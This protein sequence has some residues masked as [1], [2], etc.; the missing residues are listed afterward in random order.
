MDFFAE[1]DRARRNLRRLIVLF[2]AA[3]LMLVVL[4]NSLV[5]AFL[6]LGNDYSVYAGG[7]GWRGFFAY[8]SLDRFLSVGVTVGATVGLVSLVRWIQLSSGGRHVAESMGGRQVLPQTRDPYE[9]RCLNIVEELSLAANMP[10]PSLYVLPDERGINA[11]AAGTTTADAVV[12]VTRGCILQLRRDELQG[13]I[14]H[15]FSHILNGDMRLGIRLAALLKGIT[16][17]GDVGHFLLRA[18]VH[19]IGPGSRRRGDRS[20]ALPLLG[21]GL[22]I[23][24]WLGALAA[25]L[26]KAAISRQK[27][28]LADAS[29]VQ[30]SRDNRGIADALKVIGGFRPGSFIHSARAAELGHIF[31]GEVRHSLWD[32][33][34]THPPLELRIRRLEPAWDGEFIRRPE[35]RQAPMTPGN[36]EAGV[37]R[38]A[39][40]TAAMASAVAADALPAAALTEGPDTGIGVP[41]AD[42]PSVDSEGLAGAIPAELHAVVEEPLGAMAAAL[43]LVVAGN[44]AQ[45]HA[46]L[47][48]IRD[49]GARGEADSV[50][51]LLPQLEALPAG[52]RFPLLAAAMP[53]LRAMSTPQ[54]RQFKSTLL[55]VIR[56][57]RQ[58]DLFEWCLFQLL[59]H[60]LDPVY[61]QVTSS[62]P[63]HRHLGQV[64]GQIREVLS[65]LAHQGEGDS[66]RAFALAAAELGLDTL[67]LIP[68]ADCTVAGFSRAVTTL[69]DCY[70]LLKPRI[71]K[72]MA[73]AAA[74]DGHVCAAEREI[75]IA[76]AA[77]MD[78][79]LPADLSLTRA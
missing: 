33:F 62:R 36:V 65:V 44:P 22:L 15:E 25:S 67:T 34:A 75:V 4:T 40:V 3:V 14:G 46:A 58:T 26:I 51:A 11:F 1:Q 19:G 77:V 16:F 72:A 60:Y 27:E 35:V 68:A 49:G 20:P 32:G 5:A 43:G 69:A 30:F 61:L 55:A 78:C 56:A 79:P 64:R 18:G 71:L 66:E 48:A 13:V 54:Y 7:S 29:A 42:G 57:D 31:F 12:A 50:Q 9:K 52:Q 6:W 53:A 38:A 47:A 21:L 70:P 8:F 59:R 39:L 2:G 28:Y 41:I 74:D 23:I 37:E 45:R 76:V 63:R 73:L 24:G 10:V 17:I